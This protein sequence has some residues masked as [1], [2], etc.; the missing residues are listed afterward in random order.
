MYFGLIFGI[1]LKKSRETWQF[2][3]N[4]TL[5]TQVIDIYVS[6]F[7]FIIGIFYDNKGYILSIGVLTRRL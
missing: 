2:S 4:S 6:V 3:T 1:S 5:K 7:I